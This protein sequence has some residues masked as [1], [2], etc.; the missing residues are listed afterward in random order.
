MLVLALPLIFQAFSV[1]N[2]HRDATLHTR[3]P[4]L[5]IVAD[6]LQIIELKSMKSPLWNTAGSQ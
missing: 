3:P 4:G 5:S 6:F 2:W 1:F